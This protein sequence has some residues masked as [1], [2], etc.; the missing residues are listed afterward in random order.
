MQIPQGGKQCFGARKQMNLGATKLALG[1]QK[2]LYWTAHARAKMRF[3]KLSEGRVKR[4]L[5][6]PERIETGIA[7]DTIALMQTQRGPKKSYEIWTMVSEDKTKRKVVSAWKYPGKT[8][9]GEPL[10]AEIL[11]EFRSCLS[12]V[13]VEKSAISAQNIMKNFLKRRKPIFSGNMNL[14]KK[15]WFK[16]PMLAR[17]TKTEPMTKK[18]ANAL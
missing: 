15:K 10:P 12:F 6:S 9:L 13:S 4:V 17:A 11:K 2:I 7:P 8:K 14:I 18:P 1:R 5:H 3:Y 16:R